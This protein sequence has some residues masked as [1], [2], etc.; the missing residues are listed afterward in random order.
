MAKDD[1]K[2][3]KRWLERGI[4]FY[5]ASSIN[6]STQNLF[7]LSVSLRKIWID[8]C[9]IYKNLFKITYNLEISISQMEQK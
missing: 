2:D 8:E 5:Y 4:S 9:Q 7:C 3:A 6:H 1:S